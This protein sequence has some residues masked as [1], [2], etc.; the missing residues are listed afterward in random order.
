MT[1]IAR[2]TIMWAVFLLIAL[3]TLPARAEQSMVRIAQP[4]GLVYL[5]SYVAVDQHLIAQRAKAAGLGDI[6]V[7]LTRMASGPAA[8]DMLLSGNADL[9]M[10]GFGPA[11]TIW[12]KTHGAQQVRGVMPL[13]SSPVFLISVDPRI[14]SLR[15]F[16]DGDKIS[17][18]A[19]KVTDQ[20]ITLQMAAA[21]EWGWDQ[22]FR[23]DPLT[24]SMS[25]PD[26]LI[27]MLGGHSEVKNHAAIIPFSV[28]ELESGKAHL[29]MTSDQ[30]LEPGSS[31]TVMWASAQFHDPNPK[32]YQA[33]VAAF[34]DAIALINR[35]PH[36]AAQIYVAREPQKHDL[37]WIEAMIRNPKLIT[38][39]S[40]PR[41]T[42]AHAQFMYRVGTLKHEA[43]T[44]QELFWENEA[45]KPGS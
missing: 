13:S 23:L 3:S 11:F 30:Y 26:A 45:D 41:G 15:D 35:D 1:I 44:W 8:S 5:P 27:T 16:R 37:G 4:Y 19:I 40:I 28:E 22:R 12:D 10:G 32:L 24:V 43:K 33:V 34:E 9:A 6:Q 29:V 21:K 36:L 20:A 42:L 18:S 38:Y 17:V 7:T 31:S 39:S 14:R 2:M 25:N